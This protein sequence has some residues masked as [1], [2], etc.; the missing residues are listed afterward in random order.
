MRSAAQTKP[1]TGKT[2]LRVADFGVKIALLAALVL[3]A[4]GCVRRR[5]NVRSNPPGALVYVDN[6]QIGT[7]TC[8]VDFTYYGTR[9]IRLIK[10][11]Y[12]AL[13]V[14]Q[15]IPTPWYQYPPLDFFSENLVATKIRD[16][17]TVTY[18]LAPQVI[19][20]TQELV[21]RANQLRQETQQSAVV[22]AA[23]TIP[24][25]AAPGAP[26]IVPGSTP[27]AAPPGAIP[28]RLPDVYLPPSGQP[29]VPG[30]ATEL[31]PPPQL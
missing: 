24:I 30:T 6:R 31:L 20:P 12:E 28:Q 3:P 22:P 18:D 2:G 15:P 1:A 21:D 17:R 9:E 4:G 13:A 10:P 14:N 11:G 19:V 16:N 27:V 8:S 26:V 29:I 7:T 25:V 23:A 5:L